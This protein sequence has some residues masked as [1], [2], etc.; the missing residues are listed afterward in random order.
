MS[1]K[2]KRTTVRDQYLIWTETERNEDG[3]VKDAEGKLCVRTKFLKL[4]QTSS[5]KKAR[6]D[7]LAEWRKMKLTSSDPVSGHTTSKGDPYIGTVADADT[8][9]P[10]VKKLVRLSG[11]SLR[12]PPVRVLKGHGGYSVHPQ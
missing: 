4:P 11:Q 2:E 9:H 7:G 8:P 10:I 12:S 5:K 3:I 1:K 6:E